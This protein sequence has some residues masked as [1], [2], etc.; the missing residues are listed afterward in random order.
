VA[1]TYFITLISH[2]TKG[3]LEQ[4][5]TFEEISF[6]VLLTD[7]EHKSGLCKAPSVW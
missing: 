5:V 2:I 3:I 1:S 6:E 7:K 4:K